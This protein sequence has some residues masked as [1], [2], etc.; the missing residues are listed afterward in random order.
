VIKL[1]VLDIDGCISHPF[2]TPDWES[3]SDIRKLNQ[4]SKSN[5]EIPSL[6]LCTGRPL[7]YAEAVAQWLDIKLPFV[8][9]SAAL[10]SWE[11]NKV[12][13]ILDR[14]PGN[15]RSL[16]P[17]REF[18]KWLNEEI[19]PEY[20]DLIL[21]FSKM[22]D[23][24]V[25]SPDRDQINRAYD[26]IIKQINEHFPD[27][28][29]HR[30][31]ISVNTLLAGNNKGTG[32]RLISEETGISFDQMAYIGDSEGD[33]PALQK[34]KLAFAPSNAIDRVKQI[35]REMPFE[36]SHA[37]LEAYKVIIEMNKNGEF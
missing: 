22:M 13:T 8:F 1:F 34:A 12:K 36:T 5:R 28:E 21:E 9:E 37:I 19:L 6:T 3:I 20:P 14:E 10:Y 25:V 23:A 26:R 35:A 31:E 7:P 18:K 33:I 24:G 29:A 17:I 16:A 27:L 15:G 11:E 32:F 30:T 4:L 2:R